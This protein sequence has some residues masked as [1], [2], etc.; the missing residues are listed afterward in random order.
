MGG[1]LARGLFGEHRALFLLSS[2]NE[3]ELVGTF[4]AGRGVPIN[5][6]CS[7]EWVLI[8][9]DEPFDD[10]DRIVDIFLSLLVC[11]IIVLGDIRRCEEDNR[12]ACSQSVAVNA[13][14][15]RPSPISFFSPMVELLVLAPTVKD[16]VAVDEVEESEL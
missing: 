2:S 10:D 3:E 9:E 11:D 14:V 16:L 8:F 12:C 6:E 15:G 7:A 13:C 4:D 1:L 5:D